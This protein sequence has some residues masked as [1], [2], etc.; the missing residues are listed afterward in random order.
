MRYLRVLY[1]V[2]LITAIVGVIALAFIPNINWFDRGVDIT[3]LFMLALVA[4]GELQV[5]DEG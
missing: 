2:I 1:K 4:K 5:I 3:L